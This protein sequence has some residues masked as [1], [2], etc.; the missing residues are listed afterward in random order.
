MTARMPWQRRGQAMV[1]Y[2]VAAALVAALV[3]WP[4]DGRE[5]ALALLLD[6][7]RTGY[8]KFILALSLPQ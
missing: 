6:A 4:I 1:E 3:A 2:L 7:I 5:S 8:H